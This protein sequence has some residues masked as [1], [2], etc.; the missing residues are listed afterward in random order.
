MAIERAAAGSDGK[1]FDNSIGSSA[2]EVSF[3]VDVADAS[4][5]SASESDVIS[6]G[7]DDS[8]I[9]RASLTD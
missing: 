7:R 9:V 5:T 6:S 2:S 1:E 4:R 3:D 8:L